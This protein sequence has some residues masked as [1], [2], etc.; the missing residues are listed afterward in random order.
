MAE[1]TLP[2]SV[3]TDIYAES[4]IGY[5]SQLVVQNI[6][7]TDIFLRTQATDPG[8][9]RGDWNLITRGQFLKNALGSVGEWGICIHDGGVLQVEALQFQGL[10]PNTL[11]QP[12]TEMSQFG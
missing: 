2:R 7:S 1:V 11:L 12:G 6:G 8:T 3:W 10:L 5:G 4:G 9:A